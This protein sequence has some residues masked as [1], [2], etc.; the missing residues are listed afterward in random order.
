[1]TNIKQIAYRKYIDDWKADYIAPL[2]EHETGNQYTEYVRDCEDMDEIPKPFDEWVGR[3]GFK[4]KYYRTFED[5]L[6]HEFKDEQYMKSLLAPD[7]IIE[8]SKIIAKA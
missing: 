7:E 8:Y 3:N 4:G 6:S 1:M 5:F 2:V